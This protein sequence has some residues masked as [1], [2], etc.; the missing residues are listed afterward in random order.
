MKTLVI[1]EVGV[2]HNGDLELAKCLVASAKFA[3][4]DVVKFQSFKASQLVT[5]SAQTASYQKRSVGEGETQLAMLRKLELTR[6]QHRVLAIECEKQGIEFCSTAFDAD[7]FDMLIDLGLKRVKIPSGEINN[8]PLLRYMTRLGLPVILSTG[9]ATLGEIEAALDVI[10][11]SGTARE[12][13]TVL[14]C[15]TEYPAP[16]N[17]VNLRAMVSMGLGLG[18]AVGY[19][20]H[21]LG[22]EIPIAAVALGASVVEKHLTLDKTLPGPDH[23]A[24]LEPNEFKAMVG[25]VRNLEVALGD[26]VKRPSASEL[27]NKPIARKSVVAIREIRTGELFSVDNIGTKRP[28]NGISPMRWDELIGRPAV[29]DFVIDEQIEI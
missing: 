13:V 20:D 28:G 18:V 3:G 21:T 17:E 11:S 23:L 9:M 25:A 27:N 22:I 4:A 7:S 16:M 29:R 24:S 6:E 10:E 2:N 1:A 12:L 5:T 19:S 14:Q 8:L 15:T 26:G